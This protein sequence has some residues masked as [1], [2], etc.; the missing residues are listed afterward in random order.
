MNINIFIIPKI[1]STGA[2]NKFILFLLS[3]D[4][5]FD[6]VIKKMHDICIII[7]YIVFL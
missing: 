6:L 1:K 7:N 3:E 5:N 4:V 2:R